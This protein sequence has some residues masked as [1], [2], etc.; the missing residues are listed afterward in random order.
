MSMSKNDFWGNEGKTANNIDNNQDNL[1][2][3]N[4]ED[5]MALPDQ[6]D[7]L[8][9]S[10]QK[11]ALNVLSK[12]ES[13]LKSLVSQKTMNDMQKLFRSRGVILSFEEIDSFIGMVRHSS[14]KEELPDEFFENASAGVLNNSGMY[15]LVGA[16]SDII[17]DTPENEG[18]SKSV[19]WL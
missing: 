3:I 7:E 5:D 14:L 6:K 2:N 1:M 17:N 15:N 11:E 13:F 4:L 8:V 16:T 10:D 19:L 12:D 18:F 9:V